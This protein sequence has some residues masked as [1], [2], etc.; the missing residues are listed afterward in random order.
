MGDTSDYYLMQWVTKV[1]AA[2]VIGLSIRQIEGRIQRGLWVRGAHFAVVDGVTMVNLSAID[3]L[4]AD[5]AQHQ[6][7]P[8]VSSRQPRRATPRLQ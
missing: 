8:G 7:S 2:E 3:A 5:R 4:H 6:L 1:K